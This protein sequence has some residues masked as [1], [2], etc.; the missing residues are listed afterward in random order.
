[1]IY[2]V[3]YQESKTEVPHREATHALY[4]EAD[5]VV[6]V[7]EMIA[8][9]TPYNVEYIQPLEGAHLEY[10]KKSEDFH[11]TEFSN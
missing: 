10:E 7:R 1:M 6:A 4:I 3:T 11:L 8:Q 2:K 5:S 9:N